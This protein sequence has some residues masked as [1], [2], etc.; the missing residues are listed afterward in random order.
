V[1]E[2]LFLSEEGVAIEVIYEHPVNLPRIAAVV[3]PGG[4]SPDHI[5]ASQ[6]NLLREDAGIIQVFVDLPGADGNPSTP[7]EMDHYGEQSRQAVAAALRYAA[8]EIPEE[9]G[10]FL[11]DRVDATEDLPLILVGRSNGGNLATA[12]LA[13]PNLSLPGVDGLVL[14]ETPAGPQFLLTELQDEEIGPC[15]FTSEDPGL[16]CET[17]L[18]NLVD[19]SPPFL[20]RNQN[21]QHDPPEPVYNGLE[22]GELTLHSPTL[23][24]ALPESTTRVGPPEALGWFAW[25]DASRR[26][27]EATEQYP[28]LGVILLGSEEDHAQLISSSPHVIGLGQAFESTGA[29]TRLLPDTVYSGLAVEHAEGAGLNLDNPGRLAPSPTWLTGFISAAVLEL[30]DRALHGEW[31]ANLEQPLRDSQ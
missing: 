25:R 17:D 31:Q 11:S 21:G 14:W 28:E 24:R 9:T 20:D 4:F 2:E 5:P 1:R 30:G 18:E 23:L 6:A 22:I 10:L 19:G 16:T 26:A 27:Q 12:T 13:D 29:W 3:L 7:G 8:S 15:G